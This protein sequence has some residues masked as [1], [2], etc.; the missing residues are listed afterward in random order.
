MLIRHEK[1]VTEVRRESGSRI[2]SKATGPR[3]EIPNRGSEVGGVVSAVG[4]KKLLVHPWVISRDAADP[5]EV[6]FAQPLPVQAPPMFA[7]FSDIKCALFFAWIISVVVHAEK[8]A[9]QVE[10]KFLSVTF[11]RGVTLDLGS[12]QF[13]AEDAAT[14]GLVVDFAF[15]GLDVVSLVPEGPVDPS[16]RSQSD[17]AQVMA[18][19]THMDLKS[20]GDNLS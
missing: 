5:G 20:C 13:A 4:K 10:G 7:S 19:L 6:L 2:R 15:L 1:A 8:V 3:A 17:P 18:T 12:I 9:V 11:S 16:V 14:V